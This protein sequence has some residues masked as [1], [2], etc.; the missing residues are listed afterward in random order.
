MNTVS[1]SFIIPYYSLELSLLERC[2]RSVVACA[3]SLGDYEVIVVDD[4][5]PE[6]YGAEVLVANFKEARV[7]YVYQPNAGLAAARNAGLALA[8][9]Q[10]VQFVDADDYLFEGVAP[11]LY[12]LLSTAQPDLL[13]FD[14]KK[15][16]GKDVDSNGSVK[17]VSVAYDGNGADYLLHHNLKASACCYVFRRNA[18]GNLRF[19]E[20]IV[21]EDEEFT[22]LLYIKTHRLMVVSATFYAYYQRQNSI[23]R[24]TTEEKLQRNIDD[25]VGVVKKLLE[26]AES[27]KANENKALQRR[28]YQLAQDLLYNL[29]CW[30]PERNFLNRNIAKLKSK[31]LYPAKQ[32]NPDAKHRLFGLATSNRPLITLCW[33]VRRSFK[34]KL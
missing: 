20:G 19:H 31:G 30:S 17:D 6:E 34:T 4:G 8:Q 12:S 15:V 22:P 25:G 13:A 10:Y 24:V 33:L 9:K 1:V 27:L 16:Y 2:L 11:A 3:A 32:I 23:I 18:L 21:R 26:T 14:F 5:T 28:V 29:I 7:R